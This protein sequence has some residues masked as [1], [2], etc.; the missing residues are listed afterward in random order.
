MKLSGIVDN[1]KSF[2]V[3]ADNTTLQGSYDFCF[4]NITI[5]NFIDSLTKMYNTFKGSAFIQDS[6]S[7]SFL[8]FEFLDRVGHIKLNGQLGGNY[9]ENYVVFSMYLD[10]TII[11][12]IIE[13][14]NSKIIET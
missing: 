10:Q 14:L 4:N 12:L 9:T 3:F 8:K 2:Y 5:S 1:Y 11:P 13:K 6:D 7:N